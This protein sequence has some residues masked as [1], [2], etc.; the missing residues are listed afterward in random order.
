MRIATSPINWNNEDV[1]DYRPWIPYPEILEEIRRAGYRATEW[2]K[3]L[4]DDP[5]RLERDLEA[6]GLRVVGAFVGLDLREPERHPEE[7]GRALEKAR[8]L[9][10]LGA[11]H[12]VV[13]DAGDPARRR[14]AGH[15][16]PEHALPEAAFR[17][18][19][20][21]LHRLGAALS[22]LGMEL[23]FHNHVGTYVE[24]GEEIDALLAAT[25]PERV[26][27]CLDTGHLVYGGGDLLGLLEKYRDRVAYL[28]LKDV[29]PEV[30]A[31]ARRAGWSFEE[32]LR[33][34]VFAPLGEGRVPLKEA[35][36]ML[37]EAGYEGW[38]V[39]EQDTTP[40]D[41][42]ETARKNRERLEA[43]LKEL[44]YAEAF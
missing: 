31:S 21:G 3:S 35:L 25:D 38:A 1:P 36:S 41:P 19:V 44:G 16:G 4:P 37:L 10:A 33:R 27:W 6:R 42:T 5:R 40:T 28:H 30:L 9:K 32:A 20:E 13:A 7:L 24:T 18:M 43:M 39:I 26:G 29:D 8:F 11:R 17:A 12:L 15:V 22:E 23:A 2:S 34:Y 14:A